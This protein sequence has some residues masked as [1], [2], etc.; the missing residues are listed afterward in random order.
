MTVVI[1]AGGDDVHAVDA[2]HLRPCSTPHGCAA[3]LHTNVR[4]STRICGT[5]HGLAALHTDAQLFHTDVQLQREAGDRLLPCAF[6]F[7]GA[8]RQVLGQ[9]LDPLM[10]RVR[11]I[12]TDRSSCATFPFVY[13]C[14]CYYCL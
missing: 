4:H 13:S 3:A 9:F 8:V 14:C 12:G 6:A 10:I 7:A 2:L 11:S 1:G 5:P